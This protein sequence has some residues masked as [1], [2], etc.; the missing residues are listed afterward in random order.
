M[1]PPK[2]LLETAKR[3]FQR[4][5][6]ELR[7]FIRSALGLRLGVPLDAL[8]WLADQAAR[9]GPA[10]DIE[11]E[12]VPPGFRVTAKLDL[13]KTPIRAGAVIYIERLRISG[14]ELRIELRLEE[15]SLRLA[16]ES[17]SPVALL[18]KSGA[19]DLTRPGNLLKHLP[20]LPP[21]LVEAFENK[22]VLDLMKHPKVAGNPQ[23]RRIISALTSVVTLHGIETDENHVDVA[24]RAFP[25]GLRHAA[26][27]L[28]AHILEPAAERVRAFLPVGR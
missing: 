7:R 22:L 4:N 1:N 28:R 25:E 18:I 8:R 20:N 10:T 2:V 19:L 24:F 17:F 26:R 13:M 11:I 27:S 23:A 6:D 16:G 15:V 3:Y 12:A 21:F 5:P 9:G 14:S